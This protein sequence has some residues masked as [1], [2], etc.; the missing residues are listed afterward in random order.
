MITAITFTTIL[1]IIFYLMRKGVKATHVD[2]YFEKP[3]PT[4]VFMGKHTMYFREGEME[5]WN[6]L[7]RRQRKEAAKEYERMIKKGELYGVEQED[8]TILYAT[9]KRDY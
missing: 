6:K 9:K 7:S 3:K 4:P 1:A 5:A 2:S 8:G